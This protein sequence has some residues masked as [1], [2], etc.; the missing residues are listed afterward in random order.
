MEEGRRGGSENRGVA[1]TDKQHARLQT[2]VTQSQ[3][4]EEHGR[5]ALA[6]QPVRAKS[7]QTRL[8]LAQFSP[9]YRDTYPGGGSV[10]FNSKSLSALGVYN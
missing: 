3:H 5:A 7:G 9:N 1:D 6:L 10:K 4:K 2:E 8:N